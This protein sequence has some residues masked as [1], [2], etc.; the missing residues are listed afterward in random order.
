MSSI[1]PNPALQVGE[2]LKQEPSPNLNN[3]DQSE[4]G[5]VKKIME[6][7]HKIASNTQESPITET[8]AKV[9][10]TKMK[11]TKDHGEHND[12]SSTAQKIATAFKLRIS[13]EDMRKAHKA[14]RGDSVQGTVGSERKGQIEA[15]KYLACIEAAKKTTTSDWSQRK[16][17]DPITVAE[18]G[19]RA[20]NA[21]DV[22]KS[23]EHWLNVLVELGKFKPVQKEETKEALGRKNM[24][25]GCVMAK[26]AVTGSLDEQF[27]K[28]WNNGKYGNLDQYDDTFNHC[29]TASYAISGNIGKAEAFLAKQSKETLK[30]HPYPEI[31]EYIN[32]NS[33]VQGSLDG[34]KR[35]MENYSSLA[36]QP[37]SR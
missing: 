6:N 22:K 21:E 25:V 10:L 11:S 8:E 26:L 20:L 17:L 15:E 29:M 19:W 1:N 28:D 7:Y 34:L 24:I 4:R 27:E 23:K 37:K 36:A 3:L 9:I 2:Y 16:C 33:R 12:A 5:K 31:E 32:P 30:F 13:I 35:I 14:F 18:P